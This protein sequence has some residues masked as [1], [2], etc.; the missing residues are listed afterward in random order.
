MNARQ[1][2]ARIPATDSSL[3]SLIEMLSNRMLGQMRQNFA[4]LNSI[5]KT[6]IDKLFTFA[7]LTPEDFR[8]LVKEY[9]GG[10]FVMSDPLYS[11][12]T[13]IA[14]KYYMEL[15]DRMSQTSSLLLSLIMLARLK[16]KYIRIC[17][18]E[19]M[20]ITFSLMSKKTYIGTNGIVWA[21]YKMSTDT[22]NNYK[23]KIK[24]NPNEIYYRYRYIVDIRNKFNQLMKHIAK[25]YYWTVV[26]KDKIKLKYNIDNIA[27]SITNYVI[28]NELNEEVLNVIAKLSGS[29][30]DMIYDF[31]HSIQ[32]SNSIQSRVKM[33]FNRMYSKLLDIKSYAE[34]Q[35]IEIDYTTVD[36]LKE[37]YNNF[38]RSSIVVSLARDPVFSD[39]GYDSNLVIAFCAAVIIV[40]ES[41]SKNSIS[42]SS[43]NNSD[44]SSYEDSDDQ[45]FN[46]Y[47]ESTE[48]FSLIDLEENFSELYAVNFDD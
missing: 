18:P 46:R 39:K 23:D 42:T 9:P 32:L 7:N 3:K 31:Q 28:S 24:K 40:W 37:F 22:F 15:D 36:F 26:N 4:R 48:E 34:N 20:S 29:S 5:G 19:I 10:G 2:L 8:D 16:Y 1:I 27:V 14:I 33:I 25:V 35:K 13:L 6:D 11:L 44:S 17:D 12:I 43:S 38:R 41:V 45:S 21:V 30:M 47:Y